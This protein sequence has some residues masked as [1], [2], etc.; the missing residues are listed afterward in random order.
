[1]D[2]NDPLLRLAIKR[3]LQKEASL[4]G[5]ASKGLGLI[6]RV[7]HPI[8]QAVT[9]AKGGISPWLRPNT[10]RGTA[11]ATGI[12]MAG[13]AA[14]SPMVRSPAQVGQAAARMVNAN[15]VNL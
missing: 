10:F 14:M 3:R 12:G 9:G 8:R 13:T 6:S 15:L 5:L 4:A 1:L 11:T 7:A 2:Y